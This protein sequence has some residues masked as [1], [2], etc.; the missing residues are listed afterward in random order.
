MSCSIHV[1]TLAYRRDD[2]HRS[3]MPQMRQNQEIWQ[4]E[5]LRSRRF[6]VQKMW[7]CWQR[8]ASAHMARGYP[9]MQGTT[10]V[11]GSNCPATK[12]STKRDRFFSGCCQ[13][14]LQSSHRGYQ[15]ANQQ[16]NGKARQNVDCHVARRCVDRHARPRVSGKHCNEYFNDISNTHVSKHVDIHTR[17]CKPIENRCVY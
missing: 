3:R 14:K 6:L 4:T 10:R 5:L 7:R 17:I 12:R 16:F 2:D 1:K 9:G 11:Q 15:N 13:Y 8:K